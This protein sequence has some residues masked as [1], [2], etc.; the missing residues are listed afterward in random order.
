M[1]KVKKYKFSG[2]GLS[3]KEKHNGQ[4]KFDKY[5]EIYPNLKKYSDLQLLDELVLREIYQDR[6]QQ[7]IGDLIK[8]T[9]KKAEKNT[10][11]P[12]NITALLDD[13]LEIIVKLKEK[14]GLFEEKKENSPYKKW[15]ILEK[16]FDIWR[17]KNPASRQTTCPFCKKVFFLKYRTKNYEPFISPFF[18]KDRIL[19]NKPLFDL[20]KSAKITKADVA[21]VLNV[22]EDYVDRLEKEYLKQAGN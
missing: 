12:K 20:Y 3:A 16:K 21:A 4:K 6:Y 9:S 19:A 14:L 7:I 11:P 8:E 15:E 18:A 22:S 13:N 2:T 5:L 10:L 17:E 1:S